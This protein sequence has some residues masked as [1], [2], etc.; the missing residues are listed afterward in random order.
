MVEDFV[1]EAARNMAD[2]NS[3]MLFT[4]G[5]AT[6]V[7][8]AEYTDE[9]LRRTA[10]SVDSWWWQIVDGDP[11]ASPELTETFARSIE[12][13]AASI[14]APDGRLSSVVRYLSAHGRAGSFFA[15]RGPTEG[16]VREALRVFLAGGAEARSRRTLH[17]DVEGILASINTSNGGVPKKAESTG[18]IGW[19]GL[20]GDRQHS[21]V[22]HG[23]PWQAVCLWSSE[24][25]ADLALAGHPIGAGSAG[26][27]LTLS[28]LDW[29]DVR[30]GTTVAIGDCRLEISTF[31]I[32][33]TQ[34]ARWFV[35]RDFTRIHHDRGPV[36]RVYAHVV[37]PGTVCTGDAVRIDVPD[38]A[39]AT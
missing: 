14:G 18:E 15:V 4:T 5:D 39:P 26:E 13:F 27:N 7:D 28:G 17:G 2:D 29:A 32:P 30:P 9:D 6:L 3:T 1:E 21:R 34:N 22:H 23:R 19:R 10:D 37:Q 12:Q 36:S 31:A 33:C 35:D 24:I 38:H 25:I 20:T 11:A 8:P 16:F